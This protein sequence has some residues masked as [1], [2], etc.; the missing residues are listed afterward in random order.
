MALLECGFAGHQRE[1]I[2][3]SADLDIGWKDLGHDYGFDEQDYLPY[4]E[5]KFRCSL[6]L[7]GKAPASCETRKTFHDL[8][9]P[10]P[11][12]LGSCLV[13]LHGMKLE[14][15]IPLAQSWLPT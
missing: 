11:L 15:D 12:K 13:S 3:L 4:G 10:E 1:L 5:S 6:R 14:V 2:R 9:F 8:Y 7:V